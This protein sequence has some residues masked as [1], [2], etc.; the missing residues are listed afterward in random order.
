MAHFA[1][2]K[3]SDNTVLRVMV[4]NNSDVANNGGE[5]STAAETWVANHFEEDPI[6][7]ADNGGTYPTTYWKQTSYN[8]NARYNYCA[9]GGTYDLTDEA[10]IFER[11]YASWTLD[12]NKIW[13]PPVADPSVTTIDGVEIILS[14]DETN[15][16][17]VA[18]KD[19]SPYPGY[20]WDESNSTW[21]ATGN[22]RPA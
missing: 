1:E 9:I 2:I 11:P 13:Q 17:W 16:N 6:I 5:Y 8:S 12:S 21:T 7:K 10:F 22:N 18:W 20:T 14:W 3:S 15:G 4:V 19:E